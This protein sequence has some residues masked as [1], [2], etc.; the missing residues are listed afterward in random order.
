MERKLIEE[1]I[2]LLDQIIA[3]LTPVNH[4]AAVALASV[5]DEI[6]GYGHVKEKNV[7][8]ARKLQA[9]R[10]KAFLDPQQARQ[11]A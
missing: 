3:K 11:V 5:P 8:E 2:Q 7:E 9:E 4:G 6:R 1:Y 10:L